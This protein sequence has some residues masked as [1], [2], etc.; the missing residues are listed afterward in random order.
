MQI[1]GGFYIMTYEDYE[2]VNKDKEY[3]DDDDDDW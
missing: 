2:G 1:T 3:E